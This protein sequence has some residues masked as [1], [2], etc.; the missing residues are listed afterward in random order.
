MIGH[1]A[2][3][4]GGSTRSR[5]TVAAW[6]SALGA[7]LALAQGCVEQSRTERKFGRTFESSS[8]RAF[9]PFRFAPVPEGKWVDSS[10]GWEINAAPDM[11]GVKPVATTPERAPS[12]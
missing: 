2:T 12:P 1:H 6:S 10:S 3:L 4:G 7:F 11:S 8:T 9:M 5:R